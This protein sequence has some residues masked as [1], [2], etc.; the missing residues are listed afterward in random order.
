MNL[1]GKTVFVTGASSGIGLA[2]ATSFAREGCGLLLV[3]RRLNRLEDLDRALR[4]EV[5]AEVRVGSPSVSPD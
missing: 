1:T 3:A 4:S 2:C 5:G